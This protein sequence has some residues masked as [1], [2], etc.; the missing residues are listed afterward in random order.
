MKLVIEVEW[1]PARAM[2]DNSD[3]FIDYANKLVRH[4]AFRLASDVSEHRGVSQVTKMS[5]EE[6]DA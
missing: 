3:D 4:H 2:A 5:V 6:N 1:D